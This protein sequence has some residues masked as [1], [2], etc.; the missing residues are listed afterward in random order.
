MTEG[1][2][3][4]IPKPQKKRPISLL[5]NDY[6]IFALVFAQRFKL[7]L[8]SL[9]DESQCGFMRNRHIFNNIRP[10]FDLIDYS[11]LIKDDSFI[12]FLDFLKLL[13]L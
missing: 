2:I 12:L 13:I 7:V 1:V 11:D 10:I 5:N 6:N 9:I 3:C 4:L 8:D